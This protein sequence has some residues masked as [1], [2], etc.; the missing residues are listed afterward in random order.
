MRLFAV[1]FFILFSTFSFGQLENWKSIQVNPDDKRYRDEIVQKQISIERQLLNHEVLREADVVWEQRIW[2]VI[3]AREKLNRAFLYPEKPFFELLTSAI[4]QGEVVAFESDRFEYQ[5]APEGLSNVM[6]SI[7]TIEVQ[8]PVTFELERQVVK[9]EL[10]P[11][12]ITR[13]RLKEVWYFDKEASVVKV[14]ILGIAPIKEYYDDDTGVFKYE[15]P[16]FWVYFPEIR[17]FLSHHAMFNDANDA[18]LLSWTDAFE[19]RRFS[20]YIYKESNVMDMRLVDLFPDN[21]VDRLMEADRIKSELF[22]W[23]H[24][25]WSY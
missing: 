25:L 3:D 12:E 24:D 13:Y 15:A 9:S 7:D 8:D 2:R 21:G 17:E 20:S 23:E 6:L 5:I 11:L 18:S 10:D 22:N 16:L 1:S 14:R 19:L 4:Q